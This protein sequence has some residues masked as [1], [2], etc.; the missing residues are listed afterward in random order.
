MSAG[1]RYLAQR[2]DGSGVNGE[3][4][5]LDLPLS[6]VRLTSTLSGHNA[7]QAT[8]TPRH[9]RLIASDGKPL[10]TEYGTAIW[11]EHQ[12][13]IRGG[14]VLVDSGL[15]GP[16]WGLDVVGLTG[17]ADGL[18]YT[19]A[20][21]GVEIDPTD[22]LRHLWDH[23]QTQPGG[24][25]GLEVDTLKTG[26]KIGVALEQG[27]FDTENGPLTYESGPVQYAWY[28]TH[29]IG[30]EINKLA[31]ETPFDWTETH[32][33]DG[34]IIRHDLRLGY[35][36]LG[37]RREDLRFV[38]GEN[39]HVVPS[40]NH[41]GEFYASEALVLGAGEGRTMI[42]GNHS[43][44]TGRL[45]RVAVVSNSS[46]RDLTSANRV[47]AN[48]VAARSNNVEIG[49]VI[50]HSSPHAPIGSVDLGDEIYLAGRL[51]W[52]TL[53]TWVRVTAISLSPDD[54]SSMELSVI[55]P[56]RIGR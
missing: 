30:S 41:D 39:I 24:D 31:A 6:G 51:E 37:R 15:S 1:W 47:A 8:I 13:E 49:S 36:R 3:F 25:I 20:W 18:P 12:G 35:P 21:Y 2:L 10:L 46:L 40:I 50:V 17:Y 53:E 5:D 4:I 33:W 26:L 55:R 45:R 23:I 38:V 56:E 19:G 34:D 42:R 32:R 9:S 14:G 28:Q 7:L 16:D 44:P 48:E 52:T 29:D 11:A 54:S 22:C 27:E 43:R